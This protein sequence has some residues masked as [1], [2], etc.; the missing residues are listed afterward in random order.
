MD[1]A[2]EGVYIRAIHS[3]IHEDGLFKVWYA[4]GNGW[5]VIGETEFPQYD[6]NCIESADGVTFPQEGVKCVLNDRTNSEYRIGRP[7]VYRS[8]AG[9]VMNYTYGT[10]DGRYQ[11]GQAFS[12]DGREWLRDDESF[13]LKP[14]GTGWDSNHL[15]YPSV[16]KTPQGRIFAFYNGN[17][18]GK[19]GF[20][21]AELVT[22]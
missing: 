20:G 12:S 15:S 6:I 5:E 9:Y 10:T 7:R 17:N 13:G 3:V 22:A 14:S 1:W 18:M 21:Y 11:A 8:D 19:D 4:V 2:D 16:I